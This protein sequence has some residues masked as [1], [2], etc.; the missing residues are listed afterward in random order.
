MSKRIHSIDALRAVAIFFIVIA[1][2]QPFRGFGTYG[3]YIFFVIDTIGQFDV[4]FF[5]LTSGYFLAKTVNADNVTPRVV[6]S[7]RKLGSIYVFGRLLSVTAVIG[8]ALFHGV[9]ITNALVNRGIENISA[10]DLLYFGSALSVPLWFLTALIYSLVFVACFVKFRKTRYLLPVA[11]LFHVVGLIGMNYGMLVDVPFR[12]RDALFFG[13]FYVALGYHVSSIDWTPKE[14]RSHIYFAAVCVFAVAQLVEQYA[15]G[16]IIRDN[17]LRHGI[18]STGYTIS[19]IFFV[20][21]LFAY[22]LSNPQWG[23]NTIL[24]KIGRHALG[25]YLLHVPVMRL[26]RSMNRVWRP[27]IGIDLTSTLLWQL[28]LTPLVYV[29]SLGIY[30]LMAKMHVIELDGSHT[31]WLDRLWSHGRGLVQGRNPNEN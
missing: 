30:L 29:L 16:Y 24:P 18:Y 1:H 15:I 22:V 17:V 14:N 27:G 20:L 12:T 10:I 19:T 9:P 25:I 6:G 31:P 13:F 7:V 8:L 4:A 11:A 5:F 26:L 23:K 3:N 28:A 2:V 21:A